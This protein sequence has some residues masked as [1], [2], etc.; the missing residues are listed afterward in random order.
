LRN[1]SNQ[2]KLAEA[3]EEDQINRAVIDYVH[4]YNKSIMIKS[5][6]ENA[7]AQPSKAGNDDGE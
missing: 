1:S 6:T 2:L 4:N 5:F 7:C 3:G